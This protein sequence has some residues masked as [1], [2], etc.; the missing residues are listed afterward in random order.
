MLSISTQ[1]ACAENPI[2]YLSQCS[3]KVHICDCSFLR[4]I[5]PLKETQGTIIQMRFDFYG[6]LSADNASKDN[7]NN[8]GKNNARRCHIV[9]HSLSQSQSQSQSFSLEN[10]EK[11]LPG[12][13]KQA[14]TT[15]FEALRQFVVST[16]LQRILVCQSTHLFFLLCS[17]VNC[18]FLKKCQDI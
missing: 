17:L 12:R 15:N 2:Y 18:L 8:S 1:Y 13:R 14:K 4:I 11:Y 6:F 5:F 7:R 16:N 10:I 3:H 9:M